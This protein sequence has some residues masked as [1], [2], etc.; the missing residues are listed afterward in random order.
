MASA[1]QSRFVANS[2]TEAASFFGVG[3]ETLRTWI[4]RG[5]PASVGGAGERGEYDLGAMLKWCRT[6]I[7]TARQSHET[8][9][10]GDGDESKAALVREKLRVE[11]EQRQL[12]L[13]RARGALVDR[14]AAKAEVRRLFACV[15]ARF[16]AVP[17]EMATAVPPDLRA[18]VLADWKHRVR[19]VLK[20]LTALG[21]TTDAD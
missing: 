15:R 10:G 20:E 13:A 8:G 3:K 4:S 6:N 19:L 16:E 11:I 17:G 1:I 14:E 9:D 2:L 12:S 21:E 5:C 7:W 18:D